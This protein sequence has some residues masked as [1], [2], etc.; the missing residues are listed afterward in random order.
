MQTFKVNA[1]IQIVCESK[2]TR[3]AFK[4]VAILLVSGKEIDSTKICYQNRTWERYEFEDVLRR[5]LEKSRV[6][7]SEAAENDWKTGRKIAIK[8]LK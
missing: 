2:R 3:I 5:I 6:I 7:T 8:N 1:K 4:H